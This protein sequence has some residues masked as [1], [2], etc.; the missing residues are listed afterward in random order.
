MSDYRLRQ[1]LK[2]MHA[3]PGG[4]GP[5]GEA[6]DAVET[7]NT[8]NPISPKSKNFDLAKYQAE[9]DA[10]SMAIVSRNMERN[11]HARRNVVESVSNGH[12]KPQRSFLNNGRDPHAAWKRGR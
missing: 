11:R 6:G 2:D 12:W 10:V 4:G 5:V 1:F 8:Q 9:R 7:S 3:T